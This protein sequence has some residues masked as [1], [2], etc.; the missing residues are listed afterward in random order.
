MILKHHLG[1][2]KKD[3]LGW[4]RPKLKSFP[5]FQKKSMSASLICYHTN[6]WTLN[7]R[8]TSAR[9][10]V[11]L[12]QSSQS[13][14]STSSSGSDWAQSHAGNLLWLV[15]VGVPSSIFST[16]LRQNV[17]WPAGRLVVFVFILRL[18]YGSQPGSVQLSSDL[19][20]FCTKIGAFSSSEARPGQ[21]RPGSRN[22]ESDSRT[23]LF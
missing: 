12:V 18:C 14:P 2:D 15:M 4:T 7:S 6:I 21:A 19:L 8:L 1:N 17:V 3:Q 22:S 11:Y 13:T 16:F 9:A 10:R 23:D 20:L 5:L